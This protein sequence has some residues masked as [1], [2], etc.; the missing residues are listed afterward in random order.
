MLLAGAFTR[1]TRLVVPP[2]PW[3]NLVSS[4]QEGWKRATRRSLPVARTKPPPAAPTLPSPRPG[5][6]PGRTA[7][8]AAARGRGAGRCILSESERLADG[9]VCTNG[10][11]TPFV[12]RTRPPAH[13]LAGGRCLR[14]SRR[15]GTGLCSNLQSLEIRDTLL[16]EFP[17][18]F[19]EVV[20]DPA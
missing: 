2:P 11:P 18:L 15:P 19:D 14:A 17:A 4:S 16:R 13:V 3:P 7:A 9:P 8:P 1:P 5:V 12:G 6:G 20:L 10:D